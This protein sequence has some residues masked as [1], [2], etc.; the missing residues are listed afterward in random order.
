MSISDFLPGDDEDE[1][2]D[3][4]GGGFVD[5]AAD[6][7]SGAVDAATDV[8][9]SGVDLAGDT[10]DTATDTAADVSGVTEYRQSDAFEEGQDRLANSEGVLGEIEARTRTGMDFFLDNPNASVQEGVQDTVTGGISLATGDDYSDED[11]SSDVQGAVG[12]ASETIDEAVDGTALDN[13]ATD[14]VAWTGQALFA[15]PVAAAATGATGIDPT[16]DDG[17]TEGTVGAMDVFDVALTSTG[18]AAGS[19]A[20]KAAQS[21][22]EVAKGS[23][24]VL[25]RFL[26]RGTDDA[27]SAADDAGSAADDALD[28]GEGPITDGG[29]DIVDDAGSAADDTGLATVDEASQAGDDTPALLADDDVYQASRSGSSGAS[30]TTD[31]ASDPFGA[32]FATRSGEPIDVPSSVAD[33]AGSAAD[34]AADS[35]GSGDG[36]LSKVGDRLD[37]ATDAGS[38]AARAGADAGRSAASAGADAGRAA[39]GF[40]SRAA[41]D[42][43]SFLGS[44]IGRIGDDAASASDDAA[45]AADDAASAADD[46]GSAADDAGSAANDAGE[47]VIRGSDDGVRVADD[48][49]VVVRSG[50]D[51]ARAADESGGLLSRALGTTTGKIAAGATGVVAGGALLEALGTFDSLSMTDPATG[52]SFQLVQAKAYE[53]TEAR[54]DGGRAWEVR[55]NGQSNGYTVIVEANGRNV[56]ILDSNGER[57]QAKISTEQLQKAVQRAREEGS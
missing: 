29:F 38:T 50:D 33:D 6:I 55:Q 20:V 3:D 27:G 24:G 44:R 31:D 5:T 45:S 39:G 26:G 4:G 51:A 47:I 13:P 16:G 14:A 10:L 57:K 8:G 35:A 7:G 30:R 37:G 9:S 17:S 32:G 46:V 36:I 11:L 1:E 19:K 52:E 54:P 42:S 15:D 49:S 34:D 21:S 25:S 53:P 18:F 28:R 56:Y 41:D 48:G 40:L 23:G 43:V 12:G 2:E 22:D